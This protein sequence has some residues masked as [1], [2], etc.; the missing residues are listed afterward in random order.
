[1]NYGFLFAYKNLLE[2]LTTSNYEEFI[3][4]NCDKKIGRALIEGK[5]KLKAD[6]KELRLGYND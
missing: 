3:K 4:E 5:E 6:G 2:S 1:M